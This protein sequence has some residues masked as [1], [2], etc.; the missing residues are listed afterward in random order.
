M[1]LSLVTHYNR[2]SLGSI[3]D[4]VGWYNS[5]TSEEFLAP[6]LRVER[7]GMGKSALWLGRVLLVLFKHLS[8][9]IINDRALGTGHSLIKAWP[10][11]MFEKKF[12]VPQWVDLSA[13]QK[14]G[15]FTSP[16]REVSRTVRDNRLP[17]T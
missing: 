2:T 17:G 15:P 8:N 11:V 10:G 1:L 7:E 14:K 4:E 6:Q 3:L 9:L 12:Q 16:G 13:K 5:V